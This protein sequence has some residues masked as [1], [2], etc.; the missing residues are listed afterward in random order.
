MNTQ[1]IKLVRRLRNTTPRSLRPLMAHLLPSSIES[2]LRTAVQP[3]FLCVR[4]HPRSGTNWVGSLLNLHP[5]I[6]CTGEFHFDTIYHAIK[7]TQSIPSQCTSHEPVRSALDAS[8][9]DL[10]EHG[11]GSAC[12]ASRPEALWYGDR[13]SRHLIPWLP[14]ARY[15]WVLRDGRDVAVSWTFHQVRLGSEV[16]SQAHFSPKIKAYLLALARRFESTPTLFEDHPELL[17]TN[18][19]WVREIAFDWSE[20]YRIATEVMARTDASE[21][22]PPPVLLV[23]YEDIHADTQSQC[24]RMYRFLDL[25]PALAQPF[26]ANQDTSPGFAHHDPNSYQRKGAIGDWKNYFTDESLGWFEDVA[27]ASLA[28]AG[29][30][31]KESFAAV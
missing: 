3:R 18:E 16:I 21:G 13:T 2:R 12:R 30:L 14:E 23:R 24:D 6:W 19:A 31:T 5:D 17:L 27:S 10:V 29:Y 20:H 26:E 22:E 8:F 25:D 1:Q 11:I 9:I 28:E 7:A 15:I 4:G